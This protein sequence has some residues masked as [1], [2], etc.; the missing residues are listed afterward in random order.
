MH[1]SEPV[2]IH[3]KTGLAWTVFAAGVLA[4][5]FATIQVRHSAEHDALVQ[6]AFAC[7][8]IVHKVQDRLAAHA[9]ILRGGAALFGTSSPVERRDWRAY[10]E[11]LQAE[12]S[13][14]M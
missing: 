10:I 7:D 9:L 12:R 8:Q 3:A 5:A 13:V 6:I 14:S 1:E 2:D 11:T 4:T